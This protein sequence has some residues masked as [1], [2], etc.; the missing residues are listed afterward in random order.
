QIIPW[1]ALVGCLA[2]LT[3]AVIFLHSKQ[4]SF[5]FIYNTA[6]LGA[7]FTL[8]AILSVIDIS[9]FPALH[10][11][12]GAYPLLLIFCTISLA[13]IINPRVR[14]FQERLPA[15]DSKITRLRARLL[16]L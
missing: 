13:D 8:L 4:C 2:Y 15:L 5:L 16:K 9:A 6:L 11:T 1:S 10:Y 3:S 12:S 14:W 7:V